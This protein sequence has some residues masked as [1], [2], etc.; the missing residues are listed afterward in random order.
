MQCSFRAGRIERGEE[1]RGGG[2]GGEGHT[3]YSP[4]GALM[5]WSHDTVQA[6]GAGRE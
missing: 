3:T 1:G 5:Y 6:G 2:R 4:S